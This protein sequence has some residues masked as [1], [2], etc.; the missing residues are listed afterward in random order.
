MLAPEAFYIDSDGD[1]D[2]EWANGATK[3]APL[4]LGSRALVAELF[5]DV[6]TANPYTL[7]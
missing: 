6:P 4:D 3:P 1:W 2:D 7:T 5:G